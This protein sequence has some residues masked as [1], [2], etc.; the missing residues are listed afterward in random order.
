M[1][2]YLVRRARSHLISVRTFRN[3]IDI[4][5]KVLSRVLDAGIDRSYFGA[6]GL[7]ERFASIGRIRKH[8]GSELAA[9]ALDIPFIMLFITVM[10]MISPVMGLGAGLLAV[11]SLF[12]VRILRRRIL[13]LTQQRQERDKRRHAFLTESLAGIETIRS[14]GIE[15][16]ML[17]RYERFMAGS[18]PITRDLSGLV[19]FTQGV[20]GTI[21]LV[22]PVLMAG[23]GA[24]LVISDRMT[25]GGLAA[26]I[27]LTGR[28]IQPTLRIEA[29]LAGERDIRLAKR[30]VQDMLAAPVLIEGREP[31][32]EITR[33]SLDSVAAAHPS[34]GGMLFSEVSLDLRRGECISISGAD[35]SGRSTLL[36]L[37]AGQ[38]LPAEGGVAVNGRPM[39]CFDPDDIVSRIAWLSPDDTMFS[40]SLLD[41]MTGFCRERH[42]SEAIALSKQLGLHDFIMRHPEGYELKLG[43]E[44]GATLPRSV[45]DAAILVSGLVRRPDVILFDEANLSLDTPT[46]AALRCELEWRKPD[47][48]LVLVTYRP[49]LRS[50]ADRHFRLA[51][52]RLSQIADDDAFDAAGA[53]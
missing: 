7:P 46:D 47:T 15:P 14:L 34:T 48:I 5:R 33:L 11:I 29:L 32:A 45:H 30:D 24:L 3:E 39:T 38:A 4:H 26:A 19:N 6:I 23:L 8:N 36:S 41:N 20:A 53:A 37:L 28:I 52:G 10:A 17:R 31:L 22:S 27:V 50:L 12:T 18:V 51:E 35:G 44:V 49:S 21:S 43:P 16:S 25:M 1:L 40:G 2:D 42:A 13:A 9:A